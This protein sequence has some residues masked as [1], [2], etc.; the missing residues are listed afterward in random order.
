MQ[1][2]HLLTALPAL[3]ASGGAPAQVPQH[4]LIGTWTGELLGT[5]QPERRRILRV[6]AV[7]A[8]AGTATGRWGRNEPTTI[9]ISGSTL[10]FFTGENLPV[11]LTH[12]A[13]GTLE[14]TIQQNDSGRRPPYTITMTRRAADEA[15]SR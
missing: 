5:N 12:T 10:R 3:A 4:W 15:G 9:R 13:A 7:D 11:T 8:A 14:G 2:R 6:T 1:R